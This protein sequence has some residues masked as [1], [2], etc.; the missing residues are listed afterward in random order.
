MKSIRNAEI[1]GFFS[2]PPVSLAEHNPAAYE[3]ALRDAPAGA[4]VCSHCGVGIRHH[5]V[6]RDA[7]GVQRFIG[8][9]CAGRVGVEADAIRLRLTSAELAERNAKRA[10]DAAAVQEQLR[11]AREQRQER[12]AARAEKVSHVV[13]ILRRF[14]SDFHDS[15]ADQL[16]EGPLSDRQAYFV[17]KATSETG[18]R[19]KRNA[20]AWD[21]IYDLCVDD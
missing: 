13:A 6:I 9:D 7:E 8:T 1:V 4:G 5:V 12:L 20:K 17:C 16:L 11:V 19:N 21:D 3:S 18:R 2:L 14:G 15:L 10:A